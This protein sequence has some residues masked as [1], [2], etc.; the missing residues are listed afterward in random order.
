MNVRQSRLAPGNSLVT[1]FIDL[2]L[3]TLLTFVINNPEF[4]VRRLT[5][6]SLQYAQAPKETV[7]TGATVN[8]Q[9]DTTGRATWEGK[10]MAV[11]T[12][13]QR[14][15][16]ETTAEQTVVLRAE[17]TPEGQG[18]LEAFMQLEADCQ[19]ERVWQR[20]QV[21]YRTRERVVDS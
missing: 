21:Q 12:I 17:T 3:L 10:P 2:L 18:P 11:D 7:G 5:L 20:V 1:S 14:I 19:K 16:R 13:A 8:I 9:L 6:P 15:A 4:N